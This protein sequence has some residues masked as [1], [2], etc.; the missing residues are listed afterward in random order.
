MELPYQQSG[1]GE[2]SSTP[3]YMAFGP[4]TGS[5]VYLQYTNPLLMPC[6]SSVNSSGSEEPVESGKEKK[7]W[8]KDEVLCPRG[9]IIYARGKIILKTQE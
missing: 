8:N 5:Q 6:M 4:P 2:H 9:K 7:L 1:T 3:T